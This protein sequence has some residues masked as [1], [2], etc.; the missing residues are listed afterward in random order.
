MNS[1]FACIQTCAILSIQGQTP[2]RK[3]NTMSFLTSLT[4]LVLCFAAFIITYSEH[5][6]TEYNTV[7]YAVTGITSGALLLANFGTLAI[8]L[9][10]FA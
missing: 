1:Q 3:G 8:F 6:K 5:T 2:Q 10:F 7:A 9:S 4:A